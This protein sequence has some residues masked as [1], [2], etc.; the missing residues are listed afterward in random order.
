MLDRRRGRGALPAGLLAVH[1]EQP[2][3]RR[4]PQ[5]DPRRSPRAGAAAAPAVAGAAFEGSTAPAV[6]ELG[7]GRSWTSSESSRR[8][9]TD[10][11][12]AERQPRG[13]NRSI[14]LSSGSF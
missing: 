5:P 4:T 3:P 7:N 13:A 10:G 14:T 12:S 8:L 11:A 6:R 1:R 2:C 9:V